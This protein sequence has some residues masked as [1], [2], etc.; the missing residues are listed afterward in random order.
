MAVN[1]EEPAQRYAIVAAAKTIRAQ[2]NVAPRHKWPDLL[3]EAAH[4]IGRCHD[5][6]LASTK[7]LLDIAL[8]RRLRRMEQIPSLG[9]HAIAA[10]L[11]EARTAPNVS[12][13][14][15]VLCQQIRS[16]DHLAQ[17]GTGAE[18]L[19]AWPF[20]IPRVAQEIHA[21]ADTFLR[22]IRHRRMGIILVHQGDVVVDI[23]PILE[24]APK[25]V[26]DD[27]CDLVG[28]GR[29]IGDAVGDG[30]SEQ[31]AV[32]VFVLQPL[33]I[34][35]RSSSSAA[36]QEAAAAHVAGSP[37]EISDTLQPKH[38]IIDI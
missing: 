13:D 18:Q 17:D 9:F 3:S 16:G 33:A 20:A 31:V 24:H 2:T 19:D 38:R 25:P 26:L 5:R 29:I 1:F 35:R 32:T 7:A 21:A 30:R 4:V 10:E 36:Q 34:E 37:S 14:A 22:A 12:V 15:E 11:I 8:A 6:S 23:L 28:E 27:H